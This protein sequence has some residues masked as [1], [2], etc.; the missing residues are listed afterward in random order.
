MR[1]FKNILAVYGD[2]I[3]ADDVFTQAVEL[4]RANKARLTL[5]DVLSERYATPASLEERRKRLNRLVPAITAEGVTSVSVD[6]LIGTPFL[7]IVRHVLAAG[8]DLVIASADDGMS[9]RNVYFRQHRY[10][11]H[12]QVPLPR[13]G[14]QARPV[15]SLLQHP[16]LYRS[17]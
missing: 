4:A 12:A 14:G 9:L 16:G 7:E 5:V 15:Q 2:A 1:R 17:Q 8:H 13:M 6:V 3:G 11:P 10:P